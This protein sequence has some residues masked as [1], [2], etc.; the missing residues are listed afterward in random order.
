[1]VQQAM[2]HLHTL[3]MTLR[4]PVIG[5]KGLVGELRSHLAALDAA[6]AP[7]IEFEADARIGRLSPDVEVACFRLVQEAV[8]NALKH[9]H[10]AH[11]RVA[12][13]NTGN[14]LMVSIRDDGAGFNLNAARAGAAD[15]G[16][17][18]L[19]SMRE[20]VSSVGGRFRM[21]SAIGNGTAIFADFPFD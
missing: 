12:L 16:N 3:T 20:R 11:V 9:A 17:I 1:L 2:D 15:L 5:A 14:G 13:T 4:T 21:E 10:A 7:H 8:A 18:G 6:A 19:L